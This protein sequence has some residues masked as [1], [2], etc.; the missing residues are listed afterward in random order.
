M[1]SQ[2]A[3]PGE[4]Q[5]KA[6]FL[7]NFAKFV[8]WP[9]AAFDRTN[10]PLIIGLWRQNPFGQ[11]LEK[12]VQNKFIGT[13]PLTV[14]VLTSIPEAKNCHILFISRYEPQHP[15]EVLEGVEGGNTLTV[16]ESEVFFQEGG[17]INFVIEHNKIRFQ[18]NDGAARSAGLKVSSK[19]LSL[20][21]RS[22]R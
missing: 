13:H 15:R 10:S 17:M 3:G 20:S 18:I 1:S 8:D 22:A 4:Y 19:L 14:K 16:G 21:A 12:V 9:V 5:L 6:A 11:D 7:Y 2:E